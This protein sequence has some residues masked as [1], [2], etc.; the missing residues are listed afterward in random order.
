MTS[1]RK[2]ETTSA[3]DTIITSNINPTST[4]NN[5]IYII[6]TETST[7]NNETAKRNEASIQ[8]DHP[9]ER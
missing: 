4:Y 7:N 5:D 8:P 6:T 1:L 2:H 9:P 3:T